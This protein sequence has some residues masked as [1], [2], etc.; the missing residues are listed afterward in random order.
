MSAQMTTLQSDDDPRIRRVTGY[1]DGDDGRGY[2]SVDG[3]R[4]GHSLILTPETVAPWP[5]E[6]FDDVGPEHVAMLMASEPQVIVL[7]TGRTQRFL[8]ASLS[9]ACIGKGIGIE[10]MTTAAACRTYNLLAGEGRAVA[11]GLLVE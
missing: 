2:I 1:G 11:A 7:G 10:T 9:E 3:Q 5:P 4:F 8:P 6:S